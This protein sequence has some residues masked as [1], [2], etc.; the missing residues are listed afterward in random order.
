MHTYE[1]L[2]DSQL[3]GIDRL[4]ETDATLYIAP[5]GH[6]KTVVAGTAIK[7]LLGEGIL[8]RVLV[9]APL[10]V[11]TL[12]WA[13][14]GMRW[15]H[16]DTFW[17][18]VGIACGNA[19]NR[20]NIIDNTL[21]D[22]V[23]INYENL[24]W[25]FEQYPSHNFDGLVIDEITKMKTVSGA[26]YKALKRQLKKFNWRCGLTATTG[27]ETMT[28]IFG[29]CF[30]LDDGKALGRNK[31]KFKRKYFY[32]TDY[33]Q[34]RWEQL[35]GMERSLAEAVRDLLYVAEEVP[36]YDGQI[37]DEVHLVKTPESALRTYRN[38]ARNNVLTTPRYTIAAPNAAVLQ[39]KLHQIACGS[40]YDEEATPHCIHLTKM[41]VLNTVRSAIDSPV[42]IAYQYKFEHEK[43]KAL[44]PDSKTLTGQNPEKTEEILKAWT[45]GTLSELLVHPKSAAHGINL[46]YGPCTTL[47]CLSPIW[48]ADQWDQLVKR[49][50]RRGQKSPFIRRIILI[51]AG[52]MEYDMHLSSKNKP[53]QEKAF[54]KHIAKLRENP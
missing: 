14:E 24:A 41:N 8:N 17:H 4:Y 40:V 51:A 36:S 30:L 2:K 1:S 34:H 33:D 28:D 53:L 3:N 42:L 29:Q 46:Q 47:I 19:D 20:C 9:I 49:L 35:P 52:T 25:L 18:H 21:F 43:L 32:P 26:G 45:Q 44:F 5:Q 6:G 22:V 12:S 13:H 11:A 39:E 27:I 48:S 50:A 54:F 31:D 15:H 7:E 23:V 16:L 10:K 37:I 38:M